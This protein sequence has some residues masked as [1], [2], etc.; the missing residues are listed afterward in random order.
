MFIVLGEDNRLGRARFRDTCE[1]VYMVVSLVPMGF[2]TTYGSV[3]RLLGVHPRVV[4]ACL[5]LN[6]NP[7]VVPC[8]RVVMSN[9]G[10]GG[11]SLGG[12]GVKRRLLEL[13]G[14]C[15]DEWGRVCREKIL[16]VYAMLMGDG[17]TSPR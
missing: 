5:R 7:I 3:A 17:A 1:A 13:E 12:P 11:Y 14:V 2:V 6:D 15:F 4:A 10:L 16:D 8:H 9:G